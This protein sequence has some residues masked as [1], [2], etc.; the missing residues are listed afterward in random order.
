MGL[1]SLRM[2]FH[3]LVQFHRCLSFF[4]V[5]VELPKTREGLSMSAFLYILSIPF[6]SFLTVVPCL[7]TPHP[8]TL[9]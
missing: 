8:N 1:W 9:I 2:E 5:Q 6:F 7:P 3:D 4:E